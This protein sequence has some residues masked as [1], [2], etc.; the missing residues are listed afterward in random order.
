MRKGLTKRDQEALKSKCESAESALDMVI[1]Q[2]REKLE[3]AQEWM[4]ERSEMWW[5]GDSAQEFE[6]WVN[7]LEFKIEE[8]ENLKEEMSFESMEDIL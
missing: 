2:L 5:E 4:D 8:L 6:D 7:E 1:E 3:T